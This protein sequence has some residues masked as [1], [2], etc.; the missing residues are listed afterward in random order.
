M[1]RGEVEERFKRDGGLQSRESTRYAF[2]SCPD[3]TIKVGIKFKEANAADQNSF[4]KSDIV[5]E[6]SKPYLEYF[7]TD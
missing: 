2:P 7:T 1:T 4:P 6:V 5:V 3:I